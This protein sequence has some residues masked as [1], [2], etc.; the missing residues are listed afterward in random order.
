[1]TLVQGIAASQ[2]VRAV[3]AKGYFEVPQEEMKRRKEMKIKTTEMTFT[4]EQTSRGYK[5]DNAQCH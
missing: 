4:S 5:V 3:R 2:A 1:M